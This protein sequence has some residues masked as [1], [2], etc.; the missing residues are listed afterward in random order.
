MSPEYFI[1]IME[2]EGTWTALGSRKVIQF[3]LESR[4]NEPEYLDYFGGF[5]RDYGTAS[6]RDYVIKG[7]L[8]N[9]TMVTGTSQLSALGALLDALRKEEEEEKEIS[10]KY[11]Q[12]KIDLQRFGGEVNE[13]LI[14][15]VVRWRKKQA[16]QAAKKKEF[17][18]DGEWDF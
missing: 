14:R 11:A 3:D 10:V 13:E 8:R 5:I 15:K 18:P 4:I 16:A 6:L 12:G 9:M 7:S 1:L 2:K 17:D